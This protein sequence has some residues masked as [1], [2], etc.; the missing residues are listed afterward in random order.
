MQRLVLLSVLLLSICCGGGAAMAF[1][2]RSPAFAD[3]AE[4]PVTYTCE[5]RDVSPPLVWQDPPA[6]TR[7][8]ALI[9]HD[10]DA[11]D[12]A[13]PRV[14]WVHWVL[15]DIPGEVRELPEDAGRVGLPRG[16]RQ[17]LNDW[18]RSGW[19]GPCPP[20]GRHCYLFELYA[21]DAPLGDV[22]RGTRTD[23]ERTMRGHVLGRAV[24]IGTYAKRRP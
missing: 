17:G 9:V 7:A 5:G 20:I 21:L 18:K 8:F 11:P 15:W 22:G 23:L 6:G 19:G 3:G 24:L 4:I 12:P 10:P 1:A 14:D 13:A 2:L 16:T